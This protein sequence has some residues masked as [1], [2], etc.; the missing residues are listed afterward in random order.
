MN[1]SEVERVGLKGLPDYGLQIGIFSGFSTE[2]HNQTIISGGFFIP[3]H[4]LLSSKWE[5]LTFD[6]MRSNLK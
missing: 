6:T 3:Q 1:R 2:A 5:H 4:L